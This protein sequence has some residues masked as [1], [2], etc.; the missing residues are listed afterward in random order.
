M[1]SIIVPLYNKEYAITDC[2]NSVFH[3]AIQCEFEVIL[4]DDGSTDSSLSIV[5]NKFLSEITSGVLKVIKQKN[6]GVSVARNIGASNSKYEYLCFL[7]ADDEWKSDFLITIQELI[8]EYPD[9]LMYS[10]G[11]YVNKNNLSVTEK[12]SG[13]KSD[14]K[15][16]VI[17]FFLAS[18]KGSIVN[19][20]KV[21]IRKK[22]FNKVQG[23]PVGAL[24]GEDLFVWIQTALLGKV[25]FTSEPL[26]IVNQIE[27]SS[28]SKRRNIVPYPLEFY[29]KNKI[30][31]NKSLRKYLFMIFYKHFGSSLISFRIKEASNILLTYLKLSLKVK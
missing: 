18:T 24:V 8:E 9:A 13:F 26:V 7:D 2:L 3:Q 20:S 16:Y 11:H 29:S 1:F 17:D 22:T 30:P 23:F 28:R 21:C 10:T 19:S 15:G 5:K 6:S 14:Y 4:V 31:N 25:A 27:D 12:C